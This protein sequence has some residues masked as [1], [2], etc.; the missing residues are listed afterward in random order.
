MTPE[1]IFMLVGFAIP[2]TIVMWV[3]VIGFV[4]G[5]YKYIKES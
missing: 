1:E 4:Y 5:F 3:L 2:F